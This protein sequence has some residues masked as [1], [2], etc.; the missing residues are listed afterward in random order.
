M[1]QLLSKPAP[2]S[3]R[4][5]YI[6]QVETGVAWKEQAIA[7]FNRHGAQEVALMMSGAI[8]SLTGQPIDPGQVWVSPDQRVASVAVDGVQFRWE[9]NRLVVV[10]PCAHCGLGQLS[11]PALHS[12]ADLGYALTAWQPHHP[13]CDQEEAVDWE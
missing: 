1:M 11:S 5:R 8:H 13:D 9:H 12:S 6:G 3:D 7:D 10:R 4:R 2:A